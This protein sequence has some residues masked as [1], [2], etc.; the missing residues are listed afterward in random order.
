MSRNRI[1]ALIFLLVAAVQLALPA[2]RI[3]QYE[4][5]LKEGRVFKFKTQPVDPYD[6]FR[7]RYVSLQFAAGVAEWKGGEN[8]LDGAEVFVRLET[9]A[10]GFAKYGEATLVAPES[11]DF[12]KAR[13]LYGSSGGKTAITLPF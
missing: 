4:Q 9:D 8:L 5:T 2:S 13:S 3:F 7:G 6:A 10:E 1:L 11:G 12:I